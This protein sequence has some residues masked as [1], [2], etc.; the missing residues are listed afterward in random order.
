VGTTL[1]A[2]R[3]PVRVQD[4]VDFFNLSNPFGRT[5][6]LRSTQPLTQ[7]SAKK[8]PGGKGSRCVGITALQISVSR[9]PENVKASKSH[10]PKACTEIA[11]S[12]CGPAPFPKHENMT[13]ESSIKNMLGICLHSCSNLSLN[14]TNSVAHNL[15]LQCLF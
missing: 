12:I 5:M 13:C 6:A 11:S 2:G 3:S 1:Q 14:Q 8:F 9:M 10:S 7:M 15:F 4:E